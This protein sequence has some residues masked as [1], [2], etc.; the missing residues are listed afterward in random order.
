MVK[1]LAK[2]VSPLKAKRTWFQFRLRSL[3]HLTTLVAVVCLVGPP[4]W[5][6]MLP[7]LFP[8]K[9]LEF[10]ATQTRISYEIWVQLNNR[11]VEEPAADDY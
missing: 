6:K 10:R 5:E 4:A 2:F 11:P 3:F 8:P 7:I 9:P 1:A